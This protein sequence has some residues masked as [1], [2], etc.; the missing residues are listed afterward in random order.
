[1][2]E[3]RFDTSFA[4]VDKERRARHGMP[5]TSHD[6]DRLR[7]LFQKGSSLKTMCE[8]MQRPAEGVLAKLISCGHLVSD[9]WGYHHYNYA[10]ANKVVFDDCHEPAPMKEV[11]MTK[12]LIES[13]VFVNGTDATNMSDAEIFRLIAK[14]EDEIGN[15]KAIKTPS[16]KLSDA[17]SKLEADVIKLAEYVD[18]RD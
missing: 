1:M 2:E 13:K 10:P 5:W 7:D 18:S 11:T 6:Y 15:L 4:G 8:A 12:N 3:T 14:T 17:I 16:K 9:T